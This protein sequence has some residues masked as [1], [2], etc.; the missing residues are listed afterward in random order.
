MLPRRA[1]RGRGLAHFWRAYLGGEPPSRLYHAQG[2]QLALSRDAIHARPWSFYRALLDELRTP[3]PVG[4][5]YLELM[6]WHVF[7]ADAAPAAAGW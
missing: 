5:Y 4:G 3:D 2:A 7:D 1:E 6:W